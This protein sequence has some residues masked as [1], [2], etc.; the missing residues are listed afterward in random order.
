MKQIYKRFLFF[1]IMVSAIAALYY[2]GIGRYVSLEQLKKHEVVLKLFVEHHYLF[3]VLVYLGSL[4]TAIL[5]GLPILPLFALAGGYLFGIIPGLVYAELGA[6]VGAVTAF[7]IYRY[8]FYQIIH[9]KYHDK[10][11][12]FES[13]VKKD[14]ASYL[15]MLQFLGMVPFFVINTVAVLADIS[16][17]TVSWTTALGAL[18]YLLVY[19]IAGS[20]LCTINSLKD[21]ISLRMFGTLILFAVLA[22]IP[23]LIKRFKKNNTHS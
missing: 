9:A 1:I 10:L 19:V 7:I 18:P 16:L 11:E 4:F 15:L 21:L 12:K 23:V 20:Q 14:G 13:Q 22:F 8:F 3:S 5:L 6:V 17:F 2:G